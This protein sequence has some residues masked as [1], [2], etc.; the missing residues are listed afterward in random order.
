[1]A[2][3]ARRSGIGER[4]LAK[5]LELDRP[6]PVLSDDEYDAFVT[7]N[8]RW[9]FAVTLL[10]GVTFWFGIA[11]MSA[12]TIVPLF[13]SKITQNPLIIGL[14]VMVAQASWYAPQ[15]FTAGPTERLDRKKP[16]VVNLGFFLE[17]VPVWLLPIAALMAA[18]APEL[19]LV[20]FVIGYAW[21]G[22]GAGMIGPAWQDLLARCFPVARRGRIFGITTFIGTGAGAIGAIFSGWLLKTY[23]YPVNFAYIFLIAAAA[24]TVSWAFIALTREPV[25]VEPRT[26]AASASVWRRL[27]QVLAQDENF[28]AYLTARMLLVVGAMGSAFITIAAVQRWSVPDSTVGIYTALLLVGQTVG[29]LLSGL[30]AD[31]A[32]HKVAMELGA[33]AQVF[34]FTLAW[35]SPSPAV[36]YV[37]FVLLGYSIGVNIVSGILITLEFSTP[38]RRPTYIGI[39]NTAVGIASAVAPLLG[40]WIATLGYGPLF[41]VGAGVT[42]LALFM[43]RYAVRDPRAA[44]PAVVVM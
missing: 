9:N 37:V 18:Q 43:L 12:S 30:L 23:A 29:N 24:I 17:R 3:D 10:D 35:L 44:P 28:R 31:R 15:L 32:G 7:R 4:L 16:V 19:A 40:G 2:V 38:D 5:L 8:Y 34:A 22:L 42:T 21:H 11:F 41:A 25:R 27:R 20:L 1:M 13:V 36:Y 14:V 33:L 26:D 39:G 6:V